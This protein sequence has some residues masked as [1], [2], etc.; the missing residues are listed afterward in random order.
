MFLTQFAKDNN[1]KEDHWLHDITTISSYSQTLKQVKWGKNKENDKLPQLNFALA[2]GQISNLPFYYRKLAGNISDVSTIKQLVADFETLK[3][4]EN[5][6][7]LVMDR[8]FYSKANI[9]LLLKNKYEFLLSVKKSLGFVREALES[10]YD[11]IT[12]FEHYDVQYEL[13][14]VTVPVEW[15]F[16]GGVDRRL[17]LHL[18][19]DIDRAAEDKKAFDRELAL[20]RGE[21]LSGKR[22]AEHVE[23][24]K[25]Y[26]S[27]KEVPVEG[28]NG[29][30]GVVVVVDEVAVGLVKRF[31]GFFALLSSEFLGAVSALEVY[32]NRDLVEKAFGDVKDWLSLRRALV[33]SEQGLDGKLFVCYVGLIFL[34]YVKGCMQR[35]GLFEHYTLQ[36]L[37]DCLD[38]IEC[39]E[40][41]DGSLRVGEVTEKQKQL[42][43]TLGVDPPT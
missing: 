42:Y 2:Q 30:G 22:K 14:S 40:Y 38:V 4:V 36:G 33:L 15:G 7:K 18:F 29:G 3:M 28:D 1:T 8:G 37:F 39:F 9:D 23:G 27:V 26:F 32:R 13:Y 21:L 20:M 17:F 35:A 31:F 25:K 34:S 16:V 5:K 12:S 10:V 24:Y 6:P 43:K 11:V 19:F 41:S